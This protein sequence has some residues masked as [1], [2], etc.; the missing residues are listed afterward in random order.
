MRSSRSLL[1]KVMRTVSRT[2]VLANSATRAGNGPPRSKNFGVL[3]RFDDQ[4]I[5]G[6]NV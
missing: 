2:L 4:F 6:H 1:P 5:V 3:S